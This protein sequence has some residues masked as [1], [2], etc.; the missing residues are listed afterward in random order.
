MNSKLGK[1]DKVVVR[2]K[3]ENEKPFKKS[4]GG[5]RSNQFKAQTS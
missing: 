5:C 2:R 4:K 1:K 3:T